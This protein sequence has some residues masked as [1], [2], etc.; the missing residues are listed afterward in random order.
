MVKCIYFILNSAAEIAGAQNWWCKN[1]EDNHYLSI[2][3]SPTLNPC[4]N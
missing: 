4:P 2:L 1:R 3:N